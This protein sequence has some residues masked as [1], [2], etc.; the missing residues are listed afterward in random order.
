MSDS[1]W[2]QALC[3]AQRLNKANNKTRHPGCAICQYKKLHHY[4]II[5]KDQRLSVYD[6]KNDFHNNFKL[7]L[8]QD[9]LSKHRFKNC[10]PVCK[11]DAGKKM[12]LLKHKQKVGAH[13]H[14]IFFEINNHIQLWNIKEVLSPAIQYF[15]SFYT[16]Y[17]V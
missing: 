12:Y 15:Q 2:T 4:V 7:L 8:K 11:L 5:G 3:S 16:T 1:V 10:W 13:V 9:T 6:K 17:L 14:W